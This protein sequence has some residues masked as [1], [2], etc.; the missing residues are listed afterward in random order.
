MNSKQLY[1]TGATILNRDCSMVVV[2]G[3]PKSQRKFKRLM[4]NRINWKEDTLENDYE[5]QCELVWEGEAATA[6]FGPDDFQIMRH[7]G[8]CSRVFQGSQ[9]RALL[10]SCAFKSYNYKCRL[11]LLTVHMFSNLLTQNRKIFN[12]KKYR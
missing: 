8:T 12:N 3:G 1:M 9:M 10:G 11:N 5:N 7:N 2:E 4:M 6:A